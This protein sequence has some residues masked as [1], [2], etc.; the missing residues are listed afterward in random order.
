MK[1]D[2][3]S[4][5]LGV[6][7]TYISNLHYHNSNNIINRSN[8]STNWRGNI[9][10]V[11]KLVIKLSNDFDN[12]GTHVVYKWIHVSHSFMKHY[13]NIEVYHTFQIFRIHMHFKLYHN[14][15]FIITL[16][17][18]KL[19]YHLLLKNIFY[20]FSFGRRNEVVW[21]REM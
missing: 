15:V 18:M 17:N 6:I 10:W 20:L 4:S 21:K 11:H 7:Q 9:I 2:F 5:L 1:N 19:F 3:D 13:L 12:S 14:L 16:V 8:G